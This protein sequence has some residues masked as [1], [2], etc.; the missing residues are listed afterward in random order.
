MSSVEYQRALEFIEAAESCADLGQLRQTIS[1]ALDRF[2][3]PYFTLGAMLREDGGAPRFTTLIRGV[4]QEWSDYYWDQKCFNVDAAVHKA[5]QS[6]APF[7]WSEIEH[8][9]IPRASSRLFDEIR[10]S[11][12][13]GGGLVI[14]VHDEN[15]F[16][17]VIALHH[18]DPTLTQQQTAALKLIAIYGIE[19][20]KEL[21]EAA[22]GASQRAPAPCPLS[23]RQREIL[24]YAAAG[25]SESDTGEILGIAGTTVRDHLEKVRDVLG[26]RTKT[27]AVAVAV[28]RGWIVL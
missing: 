6:A 8:Q 11:L 28:Q 26:V 17:G 14:P 18:D 3:V 2:G 27:Q 9:R 23:A 24:A 25:K 5:M 22:Q 19:C 10:D 7:S 20:A 16:A 13:I 12:K 1:A 21:H 4:T 15:G